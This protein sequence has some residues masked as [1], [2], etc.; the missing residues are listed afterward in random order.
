MKSRNRNVVPN[1]C[2]GSRLRCPRSSKAEGFLR[3]ANRVHALREHQNGAGMHTFTRAKR[4]IRRMTLWYWAV[5]ALPAA[6][7]C[8]TIV[9]AQDAPTLAAGT[10][11]HAIVRP[12]A[13]GV[14]PLRC[15]SRVVQTARD[16]LLL[17]GSGTCP[18][19]TYN[20]A[21]SVLFVDH[22]SRAKHAAIGFASGAAVGGVIARLVAGDGCAEDPCD[23]RTAVGFMTIGGAVIG[24]AGGLLVGARLPAGKEWGPAQAVRV[25]RVGSV[26]L[27]PD[28]R[29]SPRVRAR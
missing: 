9:R 14:D 12:T 2:G 4:E 23:V 26:T 28:L 1:D 13:N 7:L 27:R 5:R 24:A 25:L 3:D 29:F 16:T 18:L 6:L 22:G 19:G 15:E 11:V 8:S 10:R 21:V 20:G 17:S